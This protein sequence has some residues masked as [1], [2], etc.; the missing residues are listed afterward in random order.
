ME[1][2]YENCGNYINDTSVNP[3]IAE[4]AA[5]VPKTIEE[6]KEFCASKGMPLEKMR[7]F[8][9]RDYRQPKAFG[10]FKDSSGSFVVYKNKDDGTRA[11]RYQGNDEAY[12]V[13]ELFQKL[14][15]EIELRRIIEAKA[16]SQALKPQTSQQD[17]NETL[18]KKLANIIGDHLIEII[19]ILFVILPWISSFV[20]GIKSLRTGYYLTDDEVYYQ[21]YDGDFYMY[22]RLLD[23][24]I[25]ILNNPLDGPYEHVLDGRPPIEVIT[26][27]EDTEIYRELVGG[28][29]AGKSGDSDWDS[30]DSWDSGS[31]GWSSWDSSDTDWSSDW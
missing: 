16:S 17:K 21:T 6:L 7:F 24:W 10:I 12:A 15:S 3:N 22:D 31:S 11:I 14:K 4:F 28:R 1:N 20:S 19:L 25:S 29:S 18:P 23:I 8:I 30:W 2:K 27:F 13:N 26:P 5:E 9:G